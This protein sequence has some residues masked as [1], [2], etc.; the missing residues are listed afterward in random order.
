[1][2]DITVPERGMRLLGLDVR[3]PEMK[4]PMMAHVRGE[5]LGQVWGL[6]ERLVGIA[7]R[8]LEHMQAPTQ[9]FFLSLKHEHPVRI[10]SPSL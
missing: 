9:Q 4:E 6:S 2:Y 8:V 10:L 7:F 3:F 5:L 1:M